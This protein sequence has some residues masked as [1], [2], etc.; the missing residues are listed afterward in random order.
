MA[1]RTRTRPQAYDYCSDEV[2]LN[3]TTVHEPED[4]A[5]DTGLLDRHG[6]A[7]FHVPERNPIGFVHAYSYNEMKARAQTKEAAQRVLRDPQRSKSAVLANRLKRWIG[8]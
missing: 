5:R 6:N 4:D 2:F 1:Y 8:L 3:G 7:I